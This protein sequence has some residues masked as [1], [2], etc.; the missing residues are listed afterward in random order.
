ML[1]TTNSLHRPQIRHGNLGSAIEAYYRCLQP[2]EPAAADHARTP[3]HGLTSV[4]HAVHATVPS[5]SLPSL[6]SVVLGVRIAAGMHTLPESSPL[7]LR[8]S[9]ALALDLTPTLS[10][11]RPPPPQVVTVALVGGGAFVLLSEW[12]RR[13]V[14]KARTQARRTSRGQAEYESC[15]GVDQWDAEE[16]EQMTGRA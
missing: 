6:S 16:E 5:P 10:S 4:V 15:S 1:L 11:I 7:G 2:A 3:S 8:L 14:S 9:L 12:R 13:A